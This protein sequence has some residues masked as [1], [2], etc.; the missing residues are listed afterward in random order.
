MKC[1]A[2]IHSNKSPDFTEYLELHKIDYEVIYNPCFNYGSCDYT[3]DTKDALILKLKFPNLIIL[4]ERYSEISI[5]GVKT[6]V[7]IPN[8]NPNLKSKAEILFVCHST[9]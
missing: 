3:L 9:Q 6:R 7:P 2:N 1:I 4:S 5:S 8:S